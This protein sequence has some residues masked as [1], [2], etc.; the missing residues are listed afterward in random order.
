MRSPSS[1]MSAARQGASSRLDS[2]GFGLNGNAAAGAGKQAMGDVHYAAATDLAR[3]CGDCVHFQQPNACELVAGNIDP[4]ATCDLFEPA[5]GS[6]VLPPEP[7]TPG[8][9]PAAGPPPLR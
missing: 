8:A 9:A 2:L 6:D 3:S 1:D 5:R 7:V 4:S